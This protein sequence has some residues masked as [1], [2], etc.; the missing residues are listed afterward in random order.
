MTSE[1]CLLQ[2]SNRFVN[3]YCDQLSDIRK[4]IDELTSKQEPVIAEI[5]EENEKLCDRNMMR[6]L[7]EIQAVVKLYQHR[8]VI[9]KREMNS[10]QERSKNLKERA[11][12]VRQ[13]KA[14]TAAKS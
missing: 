10:L 1:E 3:V 4:Q 6:E 13:S 5:A 8:L 7:N 9:L 12:K 14:K 11:V 2:F